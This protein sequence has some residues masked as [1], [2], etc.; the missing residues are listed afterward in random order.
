MSTCRTRC[1]QNSFS[2]RSFKNLDLIEM[3]SAVDVIAM[4][5]RYSKTAAPSKVAAVEA[6]SA[7]FETEE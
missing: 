2:P 7:V 3:P 6:G 4:A 5:A 1:S